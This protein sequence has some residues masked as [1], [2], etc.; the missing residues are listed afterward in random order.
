MSNEEGGSAQPPAPVTFARRKWVIEALCEAYAQDRLT[1][2]ELE[3]RLDRANRVRTGGELDGLIEDLDL[4]GWHGPDERV[5]V[6]S[7]RDGG[8][9]TAVQV[10]GRQLVV[11]F[12]SGT[13]RRGRWV[14]ARRLSATAFQGGVELDFRDAVLAPG[15]YEIRVTAVMGGV[16]VVVPPGLSLDTSGFALMGGFEESP[17]AG[18][19]PVA[20]GPVLRIRGFAFMGGVHID[21]RLPGESATEAKRRRRRERRKER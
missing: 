7:A 5:S 6:T 4:K 8:A 11:G 2:E 18:P 13:T 14:P 16:Q 10:P 9:E 15:L 17:E 3:D 20:D 19:P 21:V 12:W 1:V